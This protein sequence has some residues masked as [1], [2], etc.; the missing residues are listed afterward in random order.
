LLKVGGVRK[1][2]SLLGEHRRQ[3]GFIR[4]I[5]AQKMQEP[6]AGKKEELLRRAVAIGGGL[7]PGRVAADH[8]VAEFEGL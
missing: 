6:V 3:G 7:T 4:M 8:D 2:V 5:P 1:K